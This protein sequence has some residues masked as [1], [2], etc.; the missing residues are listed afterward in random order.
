MP[1][2][3]Y[4]NKPKPEFDA[5]TGAAFPA[6]AQ[7]EFDAY[8]GAALPAPDPRFGAGNR[9]YLFHLMDKYPSVR[10]AFTGKGLARKSQ[11]NIMK[12][13]QAALTEG[14]PPK[15]PWAGLSEAQI[16]SGAD[17]LLRR[18][19]Q[20]PYAGLSD[21]RM[22]WGSDEILRRDRKVSTPRQV[23]ERRGFSPLE[24]DFIAGDGSRPA[25]IYFKEDADAGTTR[26]EIPGTTGF[27]EFQGQR[28]GGGSF[29]VMPGLSAADK[30]RYAELKARDQREAERRE[31]RDFANEVLSQYGDYP[32]VA[33]EILKQAEASMQTRASTGQAGL[34]AARESQQAQQ[35]WQANHDQSDKHKAREL[36][37]DVWKTN[38][39]N[40]P[41]SPEPMTQTELNTFLKRYD[42]VATPGNPSTF[43]K[44]QFHSENGIVELPPLDK[45]QAGKP[46]Y[47]PNSNLYVFATKKG[48]QP[49]L[50]GGLIDVVRY[51][52]LR[53]KLGGGAG[54]SNSALPESEE[55]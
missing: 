17:E 4:T 10:D 14:S 38:Q 33:L 42:S 8:T 41:G 19:R 48:V 47:D 25:D 44:K 5:Y 12:R 18:G 32:A 39:Q 50:N 29:S 52:D 20:N 35:Q 36:A 30:K 45:A 21:A 22:L 1:N 49:I 9:G 54:E 51:L 23:L 40:R 43:N 26:Y 11:E 6:P 2:I 3:D 31:Y 28:K 7:T 53:M 15:N 16:Q 24:Q 46:Y 34:Q 37:I 27:A 13:Q 55:D